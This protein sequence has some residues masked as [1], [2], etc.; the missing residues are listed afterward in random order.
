[1]VYVR[2]LIHYLSNTM[3]GCLIKLSDNMA[4]DCLCL[5]ISE[6]SRNTDFTCSVLDIKLPHAISPAM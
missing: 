2:P 4:I 1:M 3:Y 6:L 5:I